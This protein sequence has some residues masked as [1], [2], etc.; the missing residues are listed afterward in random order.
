MSGVTPSFRNAALVSDRLATGPISWSNVAVL[1]V[2]SG[3]AVFELT[4]AA[5]AIDCPPCPRATVP[6]IVI[7]TGEPPVGA[8]VASVHTTVPPG[9]PAGA[10]T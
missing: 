1:S 8:S 7:W 4:V 6:L 9:P 10:C 3:S 2:R 5:S